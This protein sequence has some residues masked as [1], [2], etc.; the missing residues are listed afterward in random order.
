M[1][2]PSL[3][4]HAKLLA[5]IVDIYQVLGDPRVAPRPG[6][7]GARELRL[8][9]QEPCAVGTWGEVPVREAYALAKMNYQ[10]ALDHA[11]GIAALTAAAH[12]AVSVSVLVRA[13]VEV[14]SQA[15][16]LLEP[17]IG[18][19]RRVRRM[20]ALRYR[21]ASE[22]EKTAAADGAPAHEHASYTETK[23]QV[24]E[25]ARDLGIEAPTVD[26]S[27]P[28]LIYVCGNE[29]LPTASKRVEQLLSDIDLPSA[30]P[31]FSGYSHGELFA[32]VRDFEQVALGGLGTHYRSVVTV[33]SFRGAVAVASYALY[34]PGERLSKLFGLGDM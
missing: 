17:G 5:E 6:S 30:Y 32:L 18:H 3:P 22:G 20:M 1:N 10:V 24:K 2:D 8:A 13:L 19:G 26:R 34:P 21:S 15:W 28:W 31:I 14:A 4:E 16:W 29:R 7:S 25:Y 33:D 23:A 27:K 9:E 11:S 12:S